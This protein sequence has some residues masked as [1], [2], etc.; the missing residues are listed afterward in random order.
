VNEG[1]PPKEISAEQVNAL[2]A[3]N[4]SYQEMGAVLGCSVDTL[5][6]RFAD[7][8]EKGRLEGKMSLKRKQWDVAMKGNPTMLI[9]LGKIM[10]GQKDVRTQELPPLPAVEQQ[11]TQEEIKEL[12]KELL[13][14]ATTVAK[15]SST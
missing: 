9:W 8:I 14:A 13:N 3:I 5:E 15:F 12:A 10:L 7:V 11:S 4:C 1:R 6:R 2:A